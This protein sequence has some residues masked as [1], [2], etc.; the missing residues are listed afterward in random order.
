[1]PLRLRR[2]WLAGGFALVVAL[3]IVCLLPAR[4]LP[5]V[6][7]SDFYEHATAYLFL[8]LWFA[9]LTARRR[10]L[11][12]AGALLLL[13]ATLEWLQG[14][15]ALGRSCDPVDMAANA[16]GVALGLALAHGGLGDWMLW[17]EDL[18]LET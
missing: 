9:G 13:G 16:L 2:F 15:M 5:A 17:V 1:M 6:G 7:V 11:R 3:V 18:L 14:A 8:M 12:A 4:D 10:W